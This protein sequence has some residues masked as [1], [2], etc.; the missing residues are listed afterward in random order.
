MR[1]LKASHGPRAQPTPVD[2]TVPTLFVP[3]WQGEKSP[4][5][6][7]LLPL[8]GIVVVFCLI[9]IAF[10]ALVFGGGEGKE[11]ES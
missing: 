7:L 3:S 1:P 5:L 8:G 10:L 2:T 9:S 6:Q 11:K 4:D